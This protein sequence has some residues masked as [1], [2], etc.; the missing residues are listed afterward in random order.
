MLRTRLPHLLMCLAAIARQS[1][2][3]RL[4]L[5][6]RCPQWL[7]PLM[8]RARHLTTLKFRQQ[9]RCKR[10]PRRT[11]LHLPRMTTWLLLQK[12]RPLKPLT[13][14]LLLKT[15]SETSQEF[16]EVWRPRRRRQSGSRRPRD[17]AQRT[18]RKQ[19]Q[20]PEGSAAANAKSSNAGRRK[21]DDRRHNGD[22]DR[23]KKTVAP[24]GSK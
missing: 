13:V 7:H 24:N 21:N 6:V 5:L 3:L 14:R 23:R 22:R 12:T 15:A 18:D 4:L 8:G 19:E 20:T 17:G 11:R 16:E 2:S 10:E 1:R 9:S